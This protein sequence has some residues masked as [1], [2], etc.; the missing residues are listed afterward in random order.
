[1]QVTDALKL[2]MAG[3]C[4]VFMMGLA[5]DGLAA[6]GTGTMNV[7][8]KKTS[9]ESVKSD[10]EEGLGLTSEQKNKIKLVRDE[11]KARQTAI[12]KALNIKNEEL[13]QELD[14][15]A[16][17]RAKVQPIVAEIGALQGQL[18]EN[19]VDVVFKLREIYTPKQ[20]K[21]IK[22]RLEQQRK[23]LAVKKPAKKQKKTLLK[24]K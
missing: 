19:R 15:E 10:L 14:G 13:R 3:C 22:Q 7:V 17:V 12:K 1:M 18:I 20:I 21:K 5:G 8:E 9:L 23:A 24:R 6:T 2:S 11:F 4:V 16:P